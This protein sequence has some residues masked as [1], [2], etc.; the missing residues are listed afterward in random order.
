MFLTPRKQFVVQKES[1]GLAPIYIYVP[2]M[3]AGLFFLKFSKDLVTLKLDDT[4]SFCNVKT[5][6]VFVFL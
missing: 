1:K 4:D 6:I 5:Q 2:W 3:N